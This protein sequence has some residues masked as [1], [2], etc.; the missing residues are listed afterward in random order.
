VLHATDEV[1]TEFATEP[2]AADAPLHV[3]AVRTAR[4]KYAAYSHWQPQGTTP[5]SEGQEYELYDYRTR[6]GRLEL[7]NGAGES[8]LEGSLAGLLGRAWDAELRGSLPRHLR[9]AR[10]RGFEDY[11]TVA[12]R[13]VLQAARRRAER[14]AAADARQARESAPH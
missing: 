4:A 10:E 9:V 11:F 12:R 14:E 6:P 13:A 5:L 3:A 8:P 7:H 1:V 2:Y